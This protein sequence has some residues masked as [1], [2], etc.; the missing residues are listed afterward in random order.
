MALVV[1]AHGAFISNDDRLFVCVRVEDAQGNEVSGLTKRNFKL[2]Q[3]GHLFG[4]PTFAVVALAPQLPGM[5]HLVVR[6][7]APAVDG[8]FVFW[9]QVSG[10]KRLGTGGSFAT[11]VKVKS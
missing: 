2:W 3:L 1:S 10:A 9:V 6:N 7:W 5:Y 8:T 11:V 4:A